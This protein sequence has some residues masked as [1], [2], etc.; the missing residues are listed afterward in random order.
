M[1]TNREEGDEIGTEDVE[2]NIETNL[3]ELRECIVDI[4]QIIESERKKSSEST[5][6]VIYV[7]PFI[8][9]EYEMIREMNMTMEQMVT[10]YLRWA[11]ELYVI[12]SLNRGKYR[13]KG[14]RSHME[15]LYLLICSIEKILVKN[16]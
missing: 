3:E 13:H 16:K 1:M 11:E 7:A 14:I 15:N 6:N 9:R 5:D 4:G 10:V 12:A 8:W 2:M